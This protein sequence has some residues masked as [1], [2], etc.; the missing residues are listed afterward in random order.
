MNIRSVGLVLSVALAATGCD[1]DAGPV[2]PAGPPG[3]E[4][5]PGGLDPSL[6][7]TDKLVT[8][9]GGKPA[10]SGL[11][12]ITATI[13]GERLILDEGYLPDD[14]SGAGGTFTATLAWDVAA[15]ALRLD[16]VRA[17]AAPIP[18]TY[19]YTELL[20]ADGGWRIGV[21][22]IFGIPGGALSSER[23]GSAR[24][25]QLLL[26]PEVVARELATGALT[27]TDAGVGVIG[28]VLHHRLEVAN[29]AGPLTLWIEVGSG[30]LAKITALENEHLRADVTVEAL[31][32]DWSDAGGGLRLPRRALITVD[33]ELVHDELRATLAAN[34]AVPA[35]TFTVP[36]GGQPTLIA[37][38]AR[39]GERSHQFYEMFTGVG[40][41]LAGGQTTVVE[42]ELAPGVWHL[43]GGTHHSLVVDQA[44]G[45]VVVEA[46]LYGERSEALLT[47]AAGKFPGKPVRHVVATHF[48]SDHAAGLRTF[49]AA[50]STIVA[51]DAALG[52]YRRV[53]A[54]RRTIEP[55]RLAAT[56]RLATLRGVAPGET[57]TLPD[58]ARPVDIYTVDTTHAA[59][60][61]VAVVNGVLF[62]S[63][64]YSPGISAS[65]TPLREL[66]QAITDHPE[67]P[68]ARIAGGHGGTATLAELDAL[69][70]ARAAVTSATPHAE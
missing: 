8:A 65:L 23:W 11:T 2:G 25:Q 14:P 7:A 34:A 10:V 70:N 18:G 62:V 55:D 15:G 43:S 13:T 68:V 29:A 22:N 59:D 39:R 20:R 51:G 26:H 45:L 37:S 30:R 1:G 35:T 6:S 66:R 56:P 46:P 33:G 41:P 54:A 12:T 40:I 9:M 27:G 4:G 48:H 63:D 47:W 36:D 44:D 69:I 53:F 21:D 38:E 3:P 42:D 61:L 24:R 28:G 57:L 31:Y 58:A 60:M 32:T 52:L 19:T 5:P 49:V 67:V 17:V 16:Y 50:G 64:L